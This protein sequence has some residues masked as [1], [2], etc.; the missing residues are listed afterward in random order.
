MTR[1]CKRISKN[2]IEIYDYKNPASHG[3]YLSLTFRAGC[4]FEREDECGITHFFEHVAIRN[5]NAQMQ[6]ELYKTLDREGL[7]F[8]ASTY[9]EMVQFYVTGAASDFALGAEIITRVLSPIILGTDEIKTERDR[10]KAEIREGDERG[11][12]ANF[13]AG[14][15]F[16]GTTLARSIIGTAGG[17]SRITGARLE[18]YRQR[19]TNAKNLFFYATGNLDDEGLDYLSSL[20]DGVT[21]YEGEMRENIAPV[22]EKFGKREPKV[23]IKNADFTMA[24]FTFDMDMKKISSCEADLLYDLLLGGYASRLFIEMSENRGLCYDLSGAVERYKNIGT[25]TFS[26]EVAQGKLYD[27]IALTLEILH[28]LGEREIDERDMMK[29]GYVKGTELLY[30]DLRELNFTLLYDNHVMSE[31][32]A[33]LSERADAYNSVTPT[34]LC[35]AA[36]NLFKKENL[37]LTLKGKKKNIDSQRIEKILQSF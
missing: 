3:F 13:T 15:V 1:E 2:G 30:D 7:E 22:P 11:S 18:K 27:A 20:L 29:A 31:G 4:M 14:V 5:V 21:L 37:T 19:I 28:S 26:F 33:T 32:Y 34:D 6:G 23:H 35:R 12:L 24:R 25:F 17:I 16:E 10:I 9:G 36:K 8:N